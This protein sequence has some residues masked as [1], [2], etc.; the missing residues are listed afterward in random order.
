[1]NQRKRKNNG[2]RKR[3]H[4]EFVEI[5]KKEYPHYTIV[6]K[7]KNSN[8]YNL[9]ICGICESEFLKQPRKLLEGRGCN[10]CANNT[11]VTK[12]SFKRDI[13][14]K[15][16]DEYSVNLDSYKNSIS[17]Y[18]FKHNTCGTVFKTSRHSFLYCGVRCPICKSSMSKGEQI[19][20][21]TLSEIGIEFEKEKSFDDLVIRHKLRFDFYLEIDKNRIIFEFDGRQHFE[22]SSND[23]FKDDLK[24]VQIK[25]DLKNKYCLENEID[26]FRFNY[27]QKENDI[28]EE[29]SRI[30][31]SY[32]FNDYRNF[33]ENNEKVEYTQASG[34]R[35]TFLV[36]YKM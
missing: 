35:E 24:I 18:E 7:Y 21:E 15:T 33:I 29:I 10:N 26:I 17:K 25:D 5:L 1:M 6:D 22:E 9:F 3:T 30:I 14:T 8:S 31:S 12:E 27:K 34:N 19:I 11:K 16:N 20:F 13:S 2:R 28:K 4:E 36:K 32:T 23:Y